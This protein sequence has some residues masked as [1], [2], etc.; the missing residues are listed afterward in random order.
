M[1]YATATGQIINVNEPSKLQGSCGNR[2]TSSWTTD[3][4]HWVWA[5]SEQTRESPADVK[6]PRVHQHQL[7]HLKFLCSSPG[8]GLNVT[9]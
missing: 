8:D 4:F 5:G 2:R 7:H 6:E 3:R 1:L 9:T